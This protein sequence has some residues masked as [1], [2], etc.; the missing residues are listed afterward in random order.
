M[1]LMISFWMGRPQVDNVFCLR[2]I[3]EK[4]F[5]QTK[6]THLIFIDLGKAYDGV[7]ICKVW[8]ALK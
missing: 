6:E 2:Q 8:E 3:I 4:Q 7:P 1:P 5:A